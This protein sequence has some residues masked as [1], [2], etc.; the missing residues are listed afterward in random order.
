MTR[1]LKTKTIPVTF[2]DFICYFLMFI[3]GIS[4]LGLGLLMT[5][6]TSDMIFSMG[7][8][9]C[10]VGILLGGIF[11][12]IFWTDRWDLNPVHAIGYCLRWKR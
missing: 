9:L 12:G 4:F 11:G 8:A 3:V 1:P 6:P 2:N 10:F 7:G 5:I